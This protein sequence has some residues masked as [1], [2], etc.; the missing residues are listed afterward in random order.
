MTFFGAA[1]LTAITTGVLA[2][3][4][5]ITAVLAYLAFRKQ[6]REVTA[7]EQQVSDQKE[8][9]AKQADLLKVQSDQLE[10]QR[11]QFEQDQMDRRRAQAAAVYVT[12]D[13]SILRV[14]TK[15]SGSVVVTVTNTSPRPVYDLVIDW[16]KGTAPWDQPQ[17]EAV[18]HPMGT[19]EGGDMVRKTRRLPDDVA[20]T[21]DRA[22][23]SA[24]V[25]FRDANGVHWLLTPD[26]H[27]TEEPGQGA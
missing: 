3:G 26:G 19:R 15:V 16:R 5:I 27:L 11:R 4:A 1:L 9:S 25:R 20:A 8:L 21:N 24:V 10:L 2:V 17:F 12:S 7:I 23:Y 13:L 14:N 22:L 18:L 6:S